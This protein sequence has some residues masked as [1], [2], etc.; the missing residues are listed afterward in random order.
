LWLSYLFVLFYLAIAAGAV[1]HE[2][3]FFERSVKLPFLNIELPLLAFF[4]LAPILFIVV[5]AYTLVHLVMLTEKAKRLRQALYDS[6]RNVDA[7]ARESLQWQLPSNIFIQFLAGPSGLRVGLFG[8]LLRAIAWITLVIAPVLLLLMMQIQ[9]LPFHSF[10]ISWTQRLVL[11]VNLGLIWWLWRKIMTGRE[12]DG[13]RG[14]GAWVW[15]TVG[16]ALSLGTLLFSVTVA[17]LPGEWQEDR[18]R[19]EEISHDVA[20]RARMG[21]PVDDFSPGSAI[22]SL[23][24]W[25]FNEEPDL[26]SRHRFPFSNTL[27][28]T[29]LNIYEGLGI[30]DPD[31]AKWHDY[32][33][34]ARGRDLRG[35]ILAFAN[36]AKVDFEGADLRGAS[37]SRA[38]LQGASLDSARLQGALL[39]DAQLQ[40]ASLEEAQLQGA[41]FDRAQLEGAS[42]FRAQLQGASLDSAR[43]QGALLDDAQLQDASLREAQLQGASF[44]RA[45][46]QG[47]SFHSAQLQGAKLD[48]TQLQYAQ[49]DHAHLQGASFEGANLHGTWL[50]YA[51]LDGAKITL[52]QLQS[53]ESYDVVVH[54]VLP[55]EITEAQ[56][57]RGGTRARNDADYAKALATEL[58]TLVCSGGR[59]TVYILRGLLRDETRRDGETF[60]LTPR[61]QQPSC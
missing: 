22:R 39:D 36:L 42:L 5:H 61:H 53:V 12:V 41:S 13:T 6:R 48:D 19:G 44:D 30:E 57:Y 49:L 37:L 16:L 21:R 51:E 15:T 46:L 20:D 29:G 32:V 8:W 60:T 43:V 10:L 27:V 35:A 58:K 34:R 31:K 56:R 33:F 17:T 50:D 24:D 23:H 52:Q 14:F 47:A 9:F 18:L 7:A 4:F 45:Q 11:I 28:L 40:D 59:K 2:D 26:V 38:Q 54:R 55:L 1:T 3:L 25:L